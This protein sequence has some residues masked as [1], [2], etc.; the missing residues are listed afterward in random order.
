MGYPLS[1]DENL[2]IH[3]SSR[4]EIHAA[5][6]RLSDGDRSALTPL[7]AT[8]RPLLC[9]F[10]RRAVN[11]AADA[12]DIAQES[13]IKLAAQVADFDRGRDGLSWAFAIAAFEIKSHL[14]R[15]VRRRETSDPAAIAELPD[16]APPLEN[17]LIEEQYESSLRDALAR[18]KPDDYRTLIMGA[19]RIEEP[20][21]KSAA[22]RKRRQ[23]AM[24]RLKAAW[25]EIYG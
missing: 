2:P 13:L 5:L 12:E 14:R 22:L 1:E 20:A 17:E 8:L 6:V 10:A 3:G 18:L 9:A 24:Q 4:I 11:N 15:I 21:A 7:A 25:R 16:C 23:R 19:D